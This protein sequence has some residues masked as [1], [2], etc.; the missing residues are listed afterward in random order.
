M[1]RSRGTTGADA[2]GCL[3]VAE[4]INSGH[5]RQYVSV[6]NSVEES[7]DAGARLIRKRGPREIAFVQEP[8]SVE[9]EEEKCFV[10]DDGAAKASTELIAIVVILADAVEIVGP[11]IRREF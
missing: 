6:L 7:E 5:I 10:L 11:G 4:D 1:S 9:E 2:S 3:W 8:L